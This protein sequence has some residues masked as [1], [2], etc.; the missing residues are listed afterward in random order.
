MEAVV[1][2][3][4]VVIGLG[5]PIALSIIKLAVDVGNVKGRVGLIETILTNHMGMQRPNGKEKE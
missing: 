3:M 4:R 2:D 5:I 1:L